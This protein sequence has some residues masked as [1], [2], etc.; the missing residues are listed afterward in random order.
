MPAL[1]PWDGVG[2]P[3]AARL[4]HRHT[5]WVYPSSWLSELG[6]P[7]R[8]KT[9]MGPA[10]GRPLCVTCSA[11]DSSPP[12]SGR[13]LRVKNNL[14][15][16]VRGTPSPGAPGS[17]R[18]SGTRKVA[19]RTRGGGSGPG[20][21]VWRHRDG[22][23]PEGLAQRSRVPSAPNLFLSFGHERGASNA[24]ATVNPGRC[25]SRRTGRGGPPVP[26]PW[27]KPCL[28]ALAPGGHCGSQQLRQEA[29]AMA[30][31]RQGKALPGSG[32]GAGGGGAWPGA[33]RPVQEPNLPPVASNPA[34]PGPHPG[35]TPM[36]DPH[37]FR[38]ALHTLEYLSPFWEMPPQRWTPST[39]SH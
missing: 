20:A 7:G 29:A 11:K 26:L 15:A 16:Q 6:V 10:T 27:P 23:F 25:A 31:G 1:W 33:P 2:T 21:Q 12:G 30:T 22:T 35:A 13:G 4:S 14:K 39:L 8:C 9:T 3:Q 36:Q 17:L 32:R 34:Y 38:G 18:G 19:L 28:R 24:E 37:D 5:R